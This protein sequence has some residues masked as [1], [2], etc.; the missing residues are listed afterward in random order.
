MFSPDCIWVCSFS[1]TSPSPIRS[2]L[3]LIPVMAEK[4]GARTLL[5]YSWVVMVS[6]T[7]L[8]SIPAKGWAASMNHCISASCS[9]RDS[10]ERSPISASRNFFAAS[11]SAQAGAAT[12]IRHR[13]VAVAVVRYLMQVSSQ[14]H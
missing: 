10:E 12:A 5:S 7:T 4:A 6:E 14:R 2:W 3:I 1:T 11:M 8:I 9:A 13:A